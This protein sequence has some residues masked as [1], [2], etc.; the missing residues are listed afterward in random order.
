MASLMEKAMKDMRSKKLE[1]QK[2]FLCKRHEFVRAGAQ[3][4]CENCKGEVNATNAAW[5]KMGL[6]HGKEIAG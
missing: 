2:L 3:F 5:Y 6:D 1:Q 4:V